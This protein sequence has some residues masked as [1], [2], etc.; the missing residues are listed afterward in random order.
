MT[1]KLHKLVDGVAVEMSAEEEAEMRA[2]W[3]ENVAT[4]A[5]LKY[6]DSRRAEYMPITELADALTKKAST[7]PVLRAAGEAQEQAYYEHNLA[8]KAAH[9]KPAA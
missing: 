1:E 3:A 2:E 8:V 5:A 7:D 6:K 9:P 4:A